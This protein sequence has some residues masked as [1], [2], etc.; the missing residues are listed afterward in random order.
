MF[1]GFRAASKFPLHYKGEGEARGYSTQK[2]K[3]EEIKPLETQI[4]KN[5][6]CILGSYV[7]NSKQLKTKENKKAKPLWCGDIKE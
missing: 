5:V 7:H 1:D 6:L 3:V 4:H 2:E